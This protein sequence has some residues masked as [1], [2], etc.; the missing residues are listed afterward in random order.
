MDKIIVKYKYG[1]FH[2]LDIVSIGNKKPSEIYFYSYSDL[3]KHIG[4][5][6]EFLTGSKEYELQ[7]IHC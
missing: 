5:I 7:K 4:E 3:K 2:T 6:V 1:E